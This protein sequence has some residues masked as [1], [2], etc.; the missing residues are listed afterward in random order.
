MLGSGK[1]GRSRVQAAFQLRAPSEAGLAVPASLKAALLDPGLAA[2]GPRPGSYVA[3]LGKAPRAQVHSCPT[4][5][6][7]LL[8]CSGQTLG[9]V[10][11]HRCGR[12]SRR[13]GGASAVTCLELS[14]GIAG[15]ETLQGWSSGS[16]TCWPTHQQL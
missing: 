1:V 5:S 6:R 4:W 3:E 14:I 9:R 16:V 2:V 7:A 15:V 11:W 8:Q 10:A 13:A 12:R